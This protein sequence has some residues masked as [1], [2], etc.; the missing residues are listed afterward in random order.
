[1]SITP[2]PGGRIELPGRRASALAATPCVAT[3]PC[4]LTLALSPVIP[5]RP[6]SLPRCLV[7]MLNGRA[8]TLIEISFLI[9]RTYLVVRRR[10]EREGLRAAL[11]A[12]FLSVGRSRR[13]GRETKRECVEKKKNQPRAMSLAL[14]RSRRY[15]SFAICFLRARAGNT[16]LLARRNDYGQ[17]LSEITRI[18][19]SVFMNKEEKGPAEGADGRPARRRRG[20][21]ENDEKSVHTALRAASRLLELGM[22]ASINVFLGRGKEKGSKRKQKSIN[23]E[24]TR[25]CSGVFIEKIVSVE[26]A[27]CGRF[28][29]QGTPRRGIGFLARGNVIEFSQFIFAKHSTRSG[30]LGNVEI[31]CNVHPPVQLPG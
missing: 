21:R 20:R 1:M 28:A 17:K 13:A 5:L 27:F 31:G 19:L 6:P 26:A 12:G 22:I 29:E 18:F 2:P 25:V 15:T 23:Y 16:A 30:R 14:S 3:S 10:V 8:G 24:N 9:G 4:T 11:P 7:T